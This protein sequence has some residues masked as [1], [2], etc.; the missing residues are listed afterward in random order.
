MWNHR[1]WTIPWTL[2]NG[3]WTIDKIPVFCQNRHPHKIGVFLYCIDYC[4]AYWY[5]LLAPVI[6]VWNNS[7]V[8]FRCGTGPACVWLGGPRVPGRTSLGLAWGAKGPGPDRLGF[9]L[10]GQGSWAGLAWF[11]ILRGTMTV[12]GMLIQCFYCT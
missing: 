8:L 2:D 1:P 7:T 5:C 9:G 3:Q 11:L 12:M 10:G 4:I 6:P